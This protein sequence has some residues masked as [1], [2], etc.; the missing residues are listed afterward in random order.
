MK[1]NK[2]LFQFLIEVYLIYVRIF[3]NLFHY[4]IVNITPCA[5]YTRASLVAQSVQNLPT[6]QKTGPIPGSGRS[7]GEGN[8]KPLQYPCLENPMDR[9]AGWAPVHGLQR[10]GHD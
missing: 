4:K 9:G 10:V 1:S 6:V 2:N 3:Q 8:G 7:P 5:I